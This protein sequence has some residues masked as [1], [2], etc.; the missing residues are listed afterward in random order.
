MA[1]D[2]AGHGHA[3]LQVDYLRLGANQRLHL[4]GF[5][6]GDDP[7]SADG[8]R[9]VVEWVGLIPSFRLTVKWTEEDLWDA[10]ARTCR[11]TQVKGDFTRYGGLWHVVTED[12]GTRFESEIDS[13]LEIPTIGPLIKGVVRKIMHDNA[14]RLLQ[15]IKRRVEED[16]G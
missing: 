16:A 2:K 10:A 8:N 11:F 15:A 14:E 1:L 12:A 5:A 7:R 3:A 4:R 6:G 13:E 9:L